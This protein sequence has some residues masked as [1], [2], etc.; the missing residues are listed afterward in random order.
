MT[1]NFESSPA[2]FL[3]ECI[4]ASTYFDD[5]TDAASLD[6]YAAELPF[7]DADAT[8]RDRLIEML[9]LDLRDLA[10]NAN[11]DDFL[12][13]DITRDLCDDDFAAIDRILRDSDTDLY[14]ILADALIARTS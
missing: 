10:H 6:A 1:K 11:Y 2:T 5:I 8:L 12:A 14:D 3:A 4:L 7:T 13:D 9:D